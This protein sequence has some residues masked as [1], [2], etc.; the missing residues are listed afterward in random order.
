MR[1]VRALRI[2]D[3]IVVE[4][5][6]STWTGFCRVSQRLQQT[7]QQRRFGLLGFLHLPCKIRNS[8]SQMQTPFALDGAK[9]L[10]QKGGEGV[11][12]NFH[13]FFFVFRNASHSTT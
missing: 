7:L 11:D 4:T 13:A 1:C 12:Q 8:T 6:T 10:W 9:C 2:T 3:G 5:V